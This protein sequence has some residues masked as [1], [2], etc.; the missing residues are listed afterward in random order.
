MK[1]ISGMLI[2]LVWRYSACR[3]RAFTSACPTVAVRTLEA[4]SY[5]GA[6]SRCIRRTPCR[7]VGPEA[8]SPS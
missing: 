8:P 5:Y 1:Y 4:L 3:L 2:Y 6:K 7:H